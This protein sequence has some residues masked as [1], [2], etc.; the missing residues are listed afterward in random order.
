[1]PIRIPDKLP[2]RDVLVREGVSVMDETHA[3]RQ[4]IRP[5]QIALLNLM[6]NKVRTETQI[7]RLVG[8]SPLQVE[9]T[10][11]R[12]GSHQSK[13]TPEDHLLDFYQT[14]EE[15]KDQKFDGFLVTGAPIETLPFEEVTY[16]EELENILDWTTS[17]VHSSF[18]ICWGAMA[19][20]HHFH[21]IPK[22]TLQKKAFGVYRHRNLNPSSPY[23]N[24]F[25]DDFSIPVSRWTEVRS[26]DVRKHHELEMLME[27]DV[28]GPCLIAE[29][30]GRRLYIFNHIEYD[31]TSLK[32]EYD[33]DVAKGVPIE[34]PHEYYPGNDPAKPPQNRWRSH[35][36]LLFGNWI[37]QTYQ[38][39]PFDLEEIG[40]NS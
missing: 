31:S 23:L 1:M 33:R 16:W 17:N 19:A 37:N 10:L 14:W 20:I 7:A 32:E 4:D 27:S 2:A 28:T 40:Q 15:V 6:P 9:M 29:E 12:I 5:L 22:Y 24:G 3:I 25:S 30:T 39:T 18:F 8:A 35:A 13:N 34:V 21:G 38:T 26:E 36:H 11:V